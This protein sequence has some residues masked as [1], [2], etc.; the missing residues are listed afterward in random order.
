MANAKHD[1]Q[2]LY[3]TKKQEATNQ[4]LRS[5]E[6]PCNCCHCARQQQRITTKKHLCIT[7]K[8]PIF[9]GLWWYVFFLVYCV[10]TLLPK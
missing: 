2:L 3:E 5:Y 4:G 1:F 7:I 8:I 10:L 9:D 6:C